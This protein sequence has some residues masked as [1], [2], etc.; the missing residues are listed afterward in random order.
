M[1]VSDLPQELVAL[2]GT[3]YESPTNTSTNTIDF[4]PS[5]QREMGQI[6]EI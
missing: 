5:H 1:V 4:L 3:G 6:L 2:F